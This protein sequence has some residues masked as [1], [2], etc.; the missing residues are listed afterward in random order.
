MFLGKRK[1]PAKTKNFGW[2][3]INMGMSDIFFWS[4]QNGSSEDKNGRKRNNGDGKVRIWINQW[5]KFN[6]YRKY[7]I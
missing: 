3:L 7:S 2:I 6:Q 4:P 1:I 5:K